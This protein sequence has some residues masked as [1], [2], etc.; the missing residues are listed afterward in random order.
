MAIDVKKIK[1]VLPEGVTKEGEIS[2]KGNVAELKVVGATV[3]QKEITA[4]YDGGV[5]KS[6]TLTV[7][8]ATVFQELTLEPANEVNCGGE[9][10]L[11][12]KFSKAPVLSEL[13]IQMANG[14]T[15]KE[16]AKVVG[17]NIEAT[18]TAGE[19]A[20]ENCEF[21]ANFRTDTT[22]KSAKINIVE[23][24]AV[25]SEVQVEHAEIRIGAKS[26]VTAVFD[27]APKIGEVQVVVPE[28]LTKDAE[29][30]VEG[31]NVTF[32]VTGKTAGA[33]KIQVTHN[34]VTKENTITVVTDAVITTA[35]A[36]PAEVEVGG[37]S[38]VTVAY[39]KAF[40]T[41]QE[42]LKVQY[43]EGLAEKVAYAENPEHTGGTLTVTVNA[44]GA[45]TLTLTLGGQQKVVTIT[46]TPKPVVQA[47]DVDP[48]SVEQGGTSTVKV[49]LK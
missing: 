7:T 34:K 2:L 45:K 43:G 19:V 48:K 14:F 26:K 29:P 5:S 39:D 6:V 22:V 12:A 41:G 28:G 40:V 30:V 47:V 32:T 15:V 13:A 3:G 8:E 17:N 44:E 46:G 36:E 27:K 9:V 33:Q 24:P 25:L 1:I 31:N 38:V 49:T 21:T 35:T 10:K 18:Y 16:A 37:A 42:A 11:I 20:M 4:S 23:R